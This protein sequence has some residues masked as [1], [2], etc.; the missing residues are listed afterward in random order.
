MSNTFKSAL[1]PIP[2]EWFGNDD[3]PSAE[4]KKMEPEGFTQRLLDKLK[5]KKAEADPFEKLVT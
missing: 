5:P 2:D 3:G 1:G 4:R